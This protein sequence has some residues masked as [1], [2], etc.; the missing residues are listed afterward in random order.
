MAGLKIISHFKLRLQLGQ[1][2]YLEKQPPTSLTKGQRE[3]GF[4]DKVVGNGSSD[5][6]KV[7]DFDLDFIAFDP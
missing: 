7:V 4:A 6:E 3:E 5:G 2:L 1:A